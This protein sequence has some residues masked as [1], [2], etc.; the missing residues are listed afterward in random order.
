MG[1]DRVIVHTAAVSLGRGGR[2]ELIN[3]LIS[4]T[5]TGYVLWW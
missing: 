4:R 1:S 5:I 3:S 2:G